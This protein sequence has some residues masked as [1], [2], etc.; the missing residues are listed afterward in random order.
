MPS[1][2]LCLSDS[3]T[4]APGFLLIEQDAF[5]DG[6]A[7]NGALGHSVAAELAGPVP[8]QEDHVLDPVQ[9][10]RADG[11]KDKEIPGARSFSLLRV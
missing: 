10:D 3:L 7:A 9:T 11:L 4:L 5:L 6:F 8:T 1:R 2:N